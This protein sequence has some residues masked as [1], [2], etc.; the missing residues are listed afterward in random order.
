MLSVHL[1]SLFLQL[2]FQPLSCNR[3]SKKQI[4][5]ILVIHKITHRVLVGTLSSFLHSRTVVG[6]IF[7]NCNPLASQQILLPL[8][9]IRRHVYRHLESQFGAHDADAEPQVTGGSHLNLIPAKELP[10]FTGVQFPVILIFV[11]KP[12]L[13]GQ[14]LR[15]FQHLID[16]SPGLYRTGYGE[17]A[18]HFKE[19][20]SGYTGPP[21]L[22]QFLSHGP[23]FPQLR[24]YYAIPGS[25][26]RKNLG[27]IRR[28]TFQPP[29]RILYLLLRYCFF[30]LPALRALPAVHPEH[31]FSGGSFRQYRYLFHIC[32]YS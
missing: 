21:L 12:C 31:F 3:I 1:D 25:R 19:Q 15:M 16:T 5:R 18:V 11:E 10:H 2:V 30:S 7:D 9:G 13:K 29:C 27:Q 20:F 14:V 32:F 23:D 6:L 17:M 26:L 22:V 28:K 24:F 4:D 8:F